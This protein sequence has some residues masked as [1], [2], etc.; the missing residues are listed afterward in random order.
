MGKWGCQKLSVK[1]FVHS[2][3]QTWVFQDI[4]SHEIILTPEHSPEWSKGSQLPWVK[5]LKYR[6]GYNLVEKEFLSST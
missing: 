6:V 5:A 4:S 3:T 2:E 1:C